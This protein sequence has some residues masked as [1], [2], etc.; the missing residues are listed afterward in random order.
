MAV[1]FDCHKDLLTEF[2]HFL[3]DNT[4]PERQAVRLPPLPP[5]SNEVNTASSSEHP[6][7]RCPVAGRQR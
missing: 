1:L 7:A 6:S 5:T 4:A 2:T 3:P